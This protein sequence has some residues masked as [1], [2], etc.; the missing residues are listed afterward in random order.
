MT[1]FDAGADQAHWSRVA[2]Q[3]IA[4][5]R[6]PGHDA[7]WAYRDALRSY[8]GPGTGR[9]IDVGCGE[10][11]GARVLKEL[12]YHVAAV[13]PVERFV[14]AAAQADS[15]HDY[16]VA[17]AAALPF[18]SASF[19]L[20][21][22]YNV[23]MDVADVGASLAGIR[24]ALRASGTLLVSIVH[25]FVDRGRF[26]DARPDAPFMLEDSYFG[27]RHFHGTEARDGLSM[28]FAGW[29]Q[30]LEN[31][32][33]ALE[34]AGFAVVSLR[35]PRPDVAQRPDMARWCR[36]PLFLWLKARPLA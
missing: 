29:S 24:R 17:T 31:Y 12:G 26:A 18:A 19:D 2:D 15:A 1:V 7:F 21:M 36:V 23:L 27:R 20:A 22:A 30:P 11:R 33:A 6:A 10:G 35:E 5:A 28:D 9:A 34:Q 32:M 8:I 4:W 25:P 16:A 13:D 3:W 14:A